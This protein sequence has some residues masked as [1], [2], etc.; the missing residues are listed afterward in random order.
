MHCSQKATATGTPPTVSFTTWK[1]LTTHH[2]YARGSPWTTTPSTT[3]SSR[4]WAALAAGRTVGASMGGW[5]AA[6]AW[7]RMRSAIG[8]RLAAAPGRAEPSNSSGS[9]A[10]GE[11]G[12]K[13]KKEGGA[14]ANPA[15]LRWYA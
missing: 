4:M 12:T 8:V 7:P 10:R 11:R 3:S 9:R 2:G 15:A 14:G 5:S 13:A 1:F 6:I